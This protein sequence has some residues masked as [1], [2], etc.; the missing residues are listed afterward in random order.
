[1]KNL[2]ALSLAL[3]A[4]AVPAHADP[5]TAAVAWI[6]NAMAQ[7]AIFAAV[8]QTAIGM[9]VSLLAQAIMGKPEMPGADVE[10]EIQI[11][12][13]LPLSFTVGDFATSGKR[14]YVGSWGRNTRFVTQV[15]EF[16]ALPQGAAGIWVDDE[17]GEFVAGQ[18]AWIG[19]EDPSDD[20]SWTEGPSV[21]SGSIDIGQPLTNLSDDGNRIVVKFLDGTQAAADPFL[22]R[23]FGDDEDYPWTEDMVGVGKSYAI[24]TVRYD[25]DTLT[26][27]PSFLIEPEPLALYD[28]RFDSTNGGSGAQRWEN[29]ATWQPTRNPAVIA[30][31]I[32]RGIRY[33]TEWI[34][35][36]RN[37]PAW[38]LPAAEWIAAANECDDP[39]SLSS[40]G[41]EPRYR[42][43]L[44]IKVD[45]P[46]ADYLEEIGKAA[47]MKFA[48]VGGQIK[49]IVGLP[50]SAVFSFSDDDILITEGQTFQPFYPASETYN[51]ISATYPEPREKWATKDAK[52]YTFAE[53]QEDDGGRFLPISVSY[54]AAPFAKQVQRLLRSQMR[55]FRRMR[56]HQFHLPPDAY[57]L[58]PGVDLVSWSSDRNGYSNKLFMVESV[59]KSPGMN[60]MVS[61]REV[62]PGDY[63]WSSDFESPVTITVPKNPVRFNQVI[64]GLTVTPAAVEDEESNQR[65]PAILVAC[66]GDEVG[67]THIQ[68][69]ARL[70][71]SAQV[72]ID[73]ERRFSEPH[74]WYLLNVLPAT[75]YEVRARLISDLTPR[76]QWSGWLSVT[77][78]DLGF[79]WIDFEDGVQQAVDDARAQADAAAEAAADADDKAQEVRDDHDALVGDFVGNLMDLE[80]ADEGIQ[81]RMDLLELSVSNTSYIR[82]TDGEAEG[83]GATVGGWVGLTG[84]S[85][86]Y[87]SVVV[88]PGQTGRSIAV[89]APGAYEPPHY[90]GASINGMVFRLRGWVEIN[91]GGTG[92][93]A[94]VGSS[95][96]NGPGG[97]TVLAQSDPITG[98]WQQIDLQFTVGV[99]TDEWAPAFLVTGGILRFWRVRLED[100]SAAASLEASINA[101][102]QA[103]VDETTARAAA[104]T[105]LRA[106]MEDG[107]DALSGSINQI[108]GLEVSALTGTSLGTLLQQLNVS[109]GGT[110]ATITQQGSAIADLEGNASAGYLIRAQAGGAVSLID[111]IAADGGGPPT[112]VVKIQASDILLKGSVA[113]DMLTIMDLSGNMVPDADMVSPSAWDIDG[114]ADWIM[115]SPEQFNWAQGESAG[116]IWWVGDDPGATIS[117]YGTE[118]SVLQGVEYNVQGIVRRIGTGQTIARISL[119][120][121]DFEGNSISGQAAEVAYLN[122]SSGFARGN[123]TVVAPAGARR[124]KVRLAVYDGNETAVGFSSISCIRKRTGNTLITPGGVTADLITSQTMRAL[125]GEFVNLAAANI[126]VGN[127]EIDTLQLAGESVTIPASQTQA[128]T[129][130]GNGSGNWTNSVN[131]VSINMPQS[132]S[133]VILWNGFHRY[134]NQQNRG[135][136]IRLRI[137][138]AVEWE[139]QTPDSSTVGEDWPAMSWRFNLSAG[140]HTIRIDWNAQDASL[141]LRDRT[142]IVMGTMR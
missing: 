79:S 108:T 107:D 59:A 46:P 33:G 82:Q 83:G 105:N 32:I 63:D 15:I 135:Y 42:C 29:P 11:G 64:N 74:A 3:I 127:A 137:D 112:S 66:D 121:L 87:S 20:R 48:E 13:D 98:G 128:S 1:M 7:S 110:S 125:N 113:A 57:A 43:G 4:L 38:R 89:S 104:I 123:T 96:G 19:G 122:S 27:Y 67:V 124:A 115:R 45:T 9:G 28:L 49:P 97:E 69:E 65:R 10:L 132:G 101:N 90:S 30:Y 80:A 68:I 120:W 61:L 73:T 50:G 34:Y 126:R 62:N 58:E 31:N 95:L 5:I 75:Q 23:V 140:S 93:V 47:N 12:D 85:A 2:F 81:Q 84:A 103:I 131:V 141:E 56:R 52:S 134:T 40:G 60:V 26:S 119:F 70:A 77:T 39:V 106:D 35:G 37:L 88:A 53:A 16:S 102:A 71:G 18:R 86:P 139:R 100:Y 14:K 133:V 55:D 22:T 21:P 130:S 138:G 109:A 142:L 76:S 92:R 54:P 6:G 36:G 17:A 129:V 51:T 41:T 72:V 8:V 114:D 24:V 94:I 91:G 44:E 99:D 25:D 117:K 116:E 78:P 118:F 111:L 136:G